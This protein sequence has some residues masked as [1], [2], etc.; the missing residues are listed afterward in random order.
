[1]NISDILTPKPYLRIREEVPIRYSLAMIT[2]QIIDLNTAEKYATYSNESDAMYSAEDVYKKI[3]S[4]FLAGD[5]IALEDEVFYG[6]FHYR[7]FIVLNELLG[8]MQKW[9]ISFCLSIFNGEED[10]EFIQVVNRSKKELYQLY[11]TDVTYKDRILQLSKALELIKLHLQFQALGGKHEIPSR[12]TD[13]VQRAGWDNGVKMIKAL[14]T[15]LTKLQQENIIGREGLKTR[16]FDRIQ[17]DDIDIIY[18]FKEEGKGYYIYTRH[19][20][21]EDV[22][23]VRVFKNGKDALFEQIFEWDPDADYI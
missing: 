17:A 13:L 21:I 10:L 1:M 12:L 8:P 19:R 23:S 6:E 15:V 4:A 22:T 16:I 2:D 7:D 11:T 14:L 20:F 9:D 5:Q 18:K 3:E